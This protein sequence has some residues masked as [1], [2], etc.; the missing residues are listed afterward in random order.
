L[1]EHL[2]SDQAVGLI[3]LVKNAYDADATEVV[4][5]ILGLSDPDKTTVIVRDN[6]TGMTIQDIQEKWLSPAVDHKERA[7]R[8]RRRTPLGRLPIGEKGV[9]RF[10]VHQIGRS[11]E[12]IT[13]S[14]DTRE[15]FLPI[16]WD[17]FESGDRYLDAVD[18]N[19]QERDPQVFNTGSTG[20][21]IKIR[22]AR[23]IWTRSLLEK[24]H[25]TLRRLQ[26]PLRQDSEANFKILF[27]C[28]DYPE[29]ENLDSTDIL[30]R[31]HYEFRALIDDDGRC[32]FEYKCN[33]P[34]VAAR[35]KSDSADLIPL[36]GKEMH[37][38]KPACG[39]FWINLYVWDRTR[40]YLSQSRVSSKELDAQCGVSLFRD[41]LRV[42]PYGEPGNDWLLLDQ[43]RIQDPSG[44]IGNNQVIGLIE[45]LQANNLQL[46]D[47][48]NREGLI[49]NEAFRD[50]RALSRSA[51]RVFTTYWKKDR[52]P[53]RESSSRHKGSLEVARRVATA[54]KE[55]AR[56]DV[57]VEVPLEAGFDGS[58]EGRES[59]P[60]SESNA[61]VSQRRALEILIENLEGAASSDREKEKRIERLLTLAATGLAAERVVHEF[62]RQVTAASEALNQL[63]RFAPVGSRSM[64]A[65]NLLDTCLTTLRSEFKI[66][67]PYEISDRLPQL[68]PISLREAADLAL[69]INKRLFDE[70][71]IQTSLTG[72]DFQI[73]GRQAWV[74]QVIDNLVNNACHWLAGISPNEGRQLQILL[75]RNNRQVL[76]LDNGPGIHEEAEAHLFEPFF[77]MKAGGTGLGLH[78]SKEIMHRLGGEI[79]L[80][81]DSDSRID[82][83][84]LPGAQFVL[85]FQ[86]T[87]SRRGK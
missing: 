28:P 71:G 60:P 75:D 26:S 33:H 79:R 46:R 22:R 65:I 76:V 42:L 47:T 50:L 53:A 70:Y 62:G 17:D 86:N 18:V 83:R 51:I 45:V 68:A 27:S 7:K 40:D 24:V 73:R 3:E 34:A 58:S 81:V 57:Q 25:R 38:P 8:E 35:S 84:F 78:I 49:E 66:L 69:T 9:G 37:G 80:I 56:D 55:T 30:E 4:V 64:D 5:E 87:S 29:Y 67:A 1:G 10:A 13:R 15:V 20:T 6:G 31:A 36:V 43:E 14:G 63:R 19:V 39:S 23:C 72:D 12:L 54:V 2:I 85:D 52:P 74:V 16:N 21:L 41:H 61:T 59:T 44:K 82:P 48:T 32:D 11:L 77:S